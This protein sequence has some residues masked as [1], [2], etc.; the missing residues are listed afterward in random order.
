MDQEQNSTEL[1]AEEL[2]RE[3]GSHLPTREALSLVA[4]PSAVP[5]PP[6]EEQPIF[7]EEPG[8]S[9]G[10]EPPITDQDP[11]PDVMLE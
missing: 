4:D 3:A 2:A 5:L 11:A 9:T 7:V 1:S 8:T 10:I 6:V